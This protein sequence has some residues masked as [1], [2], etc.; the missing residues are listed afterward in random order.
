MRPY[1]ENRAAGSI[2]NLDPLRR[3]LEWV[4]K[5]PVGSASQ[6]NNSRSKSK[7]RS[8]SG[9]VAPMGQNLEFN[10]SYANEYSNLTPVK[11]LLRKIITALDWIVQSPLLC[12]WWLISNTVGA[13]YGALKLSISGELGV[14]LTAWVLYSPGPSDLL[15]LGFSPRGSIHLVFPTSKQS[16]G[17]GL[18]YV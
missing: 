11:S 13:L 17:N 18:S 5:V 2:F 10:K 8:K 12:R 6:C 1:F 9:P 3:F 7:V 15:N 14:C 4:A 16:K